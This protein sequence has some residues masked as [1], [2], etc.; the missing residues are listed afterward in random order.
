MLMNFISKY[1]FVQVS[2]RK[3]N[4]KPGEN[5]AYW[6]KCFSTV[7]VSRLSQSASEY[8]PPTLSTDCVS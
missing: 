7:R 2:F 6:G 4:L 8:N 5:K 1:F 3:A